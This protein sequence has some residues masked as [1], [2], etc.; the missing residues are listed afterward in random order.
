MNRGMW[1]APNSTM[2]TSAS[3]SLFQYERM[4]SSTVLFAEE[5]HPDMAMSLMSDFGDTQTV[6]SPLLLCIADVLE[7]FAKHAAFSR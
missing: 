4:Q 1:K 2:T 5:K 7:S 6:C 3:M